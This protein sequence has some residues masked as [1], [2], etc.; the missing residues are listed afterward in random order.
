MLALPQEQ[1]RDQ[2]WHIRR[3]HIYM[4]QGHCLDRQVLPAKVQRSW[5][6]QTLT[7]S[8]HIQARLESMKCK[9]KGEGTPVDLHHSTSFSKFGGVSWPGNCPFR[10]V[11]EFNG[12]FSA[13]SMDR[14]FEHLTITW[15]LCSSFK[16]MILQLF[17]FASLPYLL[18]ATQDRFLFLSYA[19]DSALF[20]WLLSGVFRMWECW[21]FY[22]DD[23]A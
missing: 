22:H 15:I 2:Q 9:N 8:L 19:E 6:Y 10:R 14:M 23:R 5:L 17:W 13:S 1:G 16:E 11:E 18:A 12:L 21:L 3:M 20:S 4:T 7:E